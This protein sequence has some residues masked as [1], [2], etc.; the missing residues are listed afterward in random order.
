MP[1]MELFLSQS[2]EY[3][4]SIIPSNAKVFTIEAGS[5]LGWYKIASKD[6]AIGVDEFGCS[7]LKDDVLKKMNF[8]YDSIINYIEQRLNK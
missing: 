3:Q 6:C 1:S 2:K 7:G 8:D 5:T 4:E